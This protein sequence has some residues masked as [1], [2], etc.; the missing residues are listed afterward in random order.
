[1]L[2]YLLFFPRSQYLSYSTEWFK[3]TS[4]TY[5][6]MQL[7]LSQKSWTVT[8]LSWL[9]LQDFHIPKNMSSV[10]TVML[11]H[12][13]DAIS[14]RMFVTVFRSMPVSGTT[15]VCPRKR[16]QELQNW[17]SLNLI[18]KSWLKSVSIFHFWLKL[19]SSNACHIKTDIHFG[20]HLDHNSLNAR[21]SEVRLIRKL[22]R[23]INYT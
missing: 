23:E 4:E 16:T 11:L 19:D 13:Y 9:V 15:S 21:Q 5:L 22:W 7:S 18:W 3:D 8:R 2:K 10:T 17:F 6:L 20:V 14:F 12:I 1:M